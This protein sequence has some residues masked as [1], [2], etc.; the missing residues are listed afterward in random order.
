MLKQAPYSFKTHIW[1]N[2]YFTI[3]H[4]LN[5]NMN[6]NRKKVLVYLRRDCDIRRLLDI[7]KNCGELRDVFGDLDYNYNTNS[8]QDDNKIE[9]F[10]EMK[11]DITK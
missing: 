3:K 11:M 1:M 6:S 8:N 7:L 9:V 2:V 5:N 4:D 10:G